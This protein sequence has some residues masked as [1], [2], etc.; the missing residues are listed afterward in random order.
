MVKVLSVGL[1]IEHHMK[2]ENTSIY[3]LYRQGTSD[4]DRCASYTAISTAY[5]EILKE[6]WSH[7]A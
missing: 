4:I 2:G 7:V 5:L 3:S 1:G 6:P